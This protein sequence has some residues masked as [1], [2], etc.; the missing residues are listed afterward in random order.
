LPELPDDLLPRLEALL[1]PREGD[2]RP[3]SGGITNRNYVVRF[4]GTDHVVRVAGRDTALLGIDRAVERDATQAASQHGIAPEVTAFLEDVG[5]LVTRF[6]PGAPATADQVREPAVLARIA[7]ALRIIH[8][9]DALAS[10]FDAFE[11]VETYRATT[12]Q[13]GG[14][15]PDA[16]DDAAAI[17]VEIRSLLTGPDH[18]PV[19]CHDDLLPAN[20]LLDGDHVRIVDWEYAGTGDRFFDLA[21]LAV[22]NGFD[23]G[24]ERRL[25][26]LYF[27]ETATPRRC[28][29]LALMR[30]MSDF[31]EAMWGV[32]QATV[33]DLDVDFGAYADEHFERLLAAAADPAHARDLLA[34]A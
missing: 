4:G 2:P 34:A 10:R 17:A 27:A 1:G 19:P 22:N 3:L 15:I 5:C 9:G 18:D 20:L 26:E 13:R 31:R 8:A 23:A 14:S 24:D 7:A 29:H 32:V 33:S 6:V 12:L 11:I 28:A 30:I 21:N 25:L 16:Y